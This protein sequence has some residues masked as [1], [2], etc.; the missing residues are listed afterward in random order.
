MEKAPAFQTH[1]FL[2]SINASNQTLIAIP[3]RDEA[4]LQKV[5]DCILRNL[6]YRNF[7]AGMLAVEVNLSISQLNRKLNSLIGV[8]AGRLIRKIR[9]QKAAH[10]LIR[11]V[12]TIGDIAFQTG[13]YDQAHFCRSF[14]QA[15]G[16]TPLQYKTDN[17][18]APLVMFSF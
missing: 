8:P 5:K 15:F 6:A 7:N 18:D 12:D 10:L 16:R 14:K 4:L 17:A 1:L 11:N 2:S 9:L 13:F 3:S